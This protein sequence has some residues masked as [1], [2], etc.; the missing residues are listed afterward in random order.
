MLLPLREEEI[1][2]CSVYSGS[3]SQKS[4]GMKPQALLGFL[5]YFIALSQGNWEKLNSK[6]RML[7]E[8]WSN[9]AQSL[10]PITHGCQVEL[11]TVN[12]NSWPESSPSR[13]SYIC[14]QEKTS[15]VGGSCCRAVSSG[16]GC[17]PRTDLVILKGRPQVQDLHSCLT[18]QQ[19][20]L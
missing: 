5:N 7:L 2:V 3:G 9:L 12:R 16:W 14:K 18:D 13:R 17:A 6:S 8:F 11:I 19:H 10:I 4:Y 20:C 15:F 1:V